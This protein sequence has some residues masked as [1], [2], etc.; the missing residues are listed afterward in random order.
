MLAFGPAY[1]DRVNLAVANSPQRL[2]G[3]SQTRLEGDDL[4][5]S[6]DVWHC[7]FAH[8]AV[9]PSPRKTRTVSDRSPMTRRTGGGSY[10][11][12]VGKATMSLP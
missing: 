11:I 10:L 8:V 9:I 7:Q 12:N 6:Q 1:R 2:L 3:F 5:L 4:I